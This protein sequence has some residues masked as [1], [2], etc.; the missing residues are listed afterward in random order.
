MLSQTKEWRLT[1]R[2]LEW[3]TP[4]SPQQIRQL[5]GSGILYR[6]FILN[7]AQTTALLNRLL[8][9]GKQWQWTEQCLQAFTLL[10]TKLTSAPLHLEEYAFTVQHRPGKKHGNADPLSRYP[11]HQCSNQPVGVHATTDQRGSNVGGWA[12]QWSKQEFIKFQTDD[13]DIGQ[14]K[15][16]MKEGLPQTCP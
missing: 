13:P 3:P 10:K 1:L 11:C 4:T 5:F 15:R 12:L 6:H 8:E 2:I 9:K 7:F 14:M 16:W